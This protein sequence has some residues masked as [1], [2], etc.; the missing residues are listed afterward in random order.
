MRYRACL[1]VLGALFTSLFARD[2]DLT[3]VGERLLN[4][5]T[6]IL[7]GTVVGQTSEKTEDGRMIVTRYALRV[8]RAIK[9]NPTNL[10]EITEYGGVVGNQATFVSHSPSY[11]KGRTYLVFVTRDS[12]GWF[13]TMSGVDGRL[14]V[15]PEQG[16]KSVV[17]LHRGH[18]L[19][20]LVPQRSSLCDLDAFAGKLAELVAGSA[21]QSK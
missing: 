21:S 18:P 2:T 10:I 20:A 9:G 14:P 3:G 16:G 4:Q 12:L 11:A 7:V 1:I 19:S 8:D 13:R 17:R 6:Y 15:I 5:S